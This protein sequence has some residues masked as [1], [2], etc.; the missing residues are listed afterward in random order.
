MA[1]ATPS[2]GQ[3]K[4]FGKKH[5]WAQGFCDAKR[6]WAVID[7][8]LVSAVVVDCARLNEGCEDKND[9]LEIHDSLI[10]ISRFQ[11]MI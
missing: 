7:S 11:S 8:G 1:D 6:G 10:E 2:T 9:E 5:C 4:W 3:A